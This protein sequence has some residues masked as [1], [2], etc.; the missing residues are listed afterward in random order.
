MKVAIFNTFPFHYEMFGYIISFCNDR[1]YELTIYTVPNNHNKW[2][3]FYK[4]LF[5]NFNFTYKLILSKEDLDLFNNNRKLYD[6]IFLSTDNDDNF[7]VKFDDNNNVIRINHSLLERQPLIKKY[8]DVR[9]FFLNNNRLWALPCYGLLYKLDKL[10]FIK[11]NENINITV[12]GNIPKS[13]KYNV[14]VL[15]RLKTLNN[16]KMVI[17]AISRN[18]FLEQFTGLDEKFELHIHNNIDTFAMINILY[19]SNFLI[20]DIKHMNDICGS[21]EF[22]KYSEINS[23][24]YSFM[25]FGSIPLTFTTCT[26]MIICNESNK[27]YNFKNVITYNMNDND[28]IILN[29]VDLDALIHERSLLI[30]QF[31]DHIDSYIK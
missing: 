26:S 29:E 10:N 13:A 30:K 7:D 3:D 4:V 16:K 25:M 19:K 28:D 14:N 1:Q 22:N 11:D 23:D 24:P 20:V 8:I 9:P 15:N 31:H 27:Y 17:N 5:I 2:L 6:I 21:K 18:I 12:L